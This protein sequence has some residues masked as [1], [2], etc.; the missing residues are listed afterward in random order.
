MPEAMSARRPVRPAVAG[1][2]WSGT[3]VFLASC[4][5]PT[6]IGDRADA[7]SRVRRR[8]AGDALPHGRRRGRFCGML[9]HGRGM[10]NRG[11]AT[12]H[13]RDMASA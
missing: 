4:P 1:V 10:V 8:C 7:A 9:R 5:R 3:V 12:A 2:R 11:A 6:S 13:A